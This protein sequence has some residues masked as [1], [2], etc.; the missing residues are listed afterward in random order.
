MNACPF[1]A[2]FSWLQ[3]RERYSLPLRKK[4]ESLIKDSCSAKGNQ[5]GFCKGDARQKATPFNYFLSILRKI[6]AGRAP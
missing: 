5:T 3:R 4:E 1:V 6:Q 2:A